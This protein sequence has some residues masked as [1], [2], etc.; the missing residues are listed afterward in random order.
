MATPKYLL[1]QALA[2]F[3][4]LLIKDEAR[5]ERYLRDALEFYAQHSGALVR[6]R[7]EQPEI[8]ISPQPLGFNGCYNKR[9]DWII[10]KYDRTTEKLHVLDD[11]KNSPW[12]MSYFVNLR[13]WDYE[14]DLPTDLEFTL[15]ID[16]I[17]SLLGEANAQQMSLTSFVASLEGMERKGMSEYSQQRLAVEEQ[18][19]KQAHLPD[20]AIL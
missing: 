4:I 18:I 15:V 3:P 20:F 19:R 1:E 7:L 12:D 5:Q 6:T 8:L 17:E 16:H 10:T 14:T 9:G 11:P 13:H 2:R